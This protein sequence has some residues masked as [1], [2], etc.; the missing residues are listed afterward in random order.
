MKVTEIKK[1]VNL[2]SLCFAYR[3]HTHTQ[4]LYFLGAASVI[5]GGMHA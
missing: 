5:I 2:S 4:I 1:D 3:V